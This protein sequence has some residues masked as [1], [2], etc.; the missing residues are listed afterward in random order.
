VR[1]SDKDR[2]RGIFQ[3]VL[4]AFILK[5]KEAEDILCDMTEPA[6]NGVF[7]QFFLRSQEAMIHEILERASITD[8]K[9]KKDTVQDL[10]TLSEA[11]YPSLSLFSLREADSDFG[12]GDKKSSS[13]IMKIFRKF[14]TRFFL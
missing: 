8:N 6:R 2:L 10:K 9:K 5:D 1:I 11:I 12:S 7:H 4:Q 13:F 14:P 3:A